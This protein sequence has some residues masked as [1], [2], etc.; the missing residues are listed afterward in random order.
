MATRK[1]LTFVLGGPCSGKGFACNKIVEKSKGRI[2]A[3]S[4]GDLL[5][6]EIKSN[7]SLATQIVPLLEAG[8][9]V[10]AQ[11]TLQLLISEIM[12]SPK[13]CQHFLVDGFPRK[14][15]RASC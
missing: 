12:D 9:I 8:K 4:A 2:V 5:R 10:P 6:R 7:G 14:I 13:E 11:I 3:L 15:G 1:S